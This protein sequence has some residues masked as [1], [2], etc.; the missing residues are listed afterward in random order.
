MKPNRCDQKQ[1]KRIVKRLRRDPTSWAA[2]LWKLRADTRMGSGIM[3]KNKIG[4]IS[5]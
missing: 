5:Y 3:G 1:D 2:K 4:N